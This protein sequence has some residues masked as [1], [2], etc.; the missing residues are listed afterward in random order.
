[1]VPERCH[2]NCAGRSG[3]HNKVPGSLFLWDHRYGIYGIPGYGMYV[4]L[5][6]S[7]GVRYAP[8]ASFHIELPL[9]CSVSLFSPV[10]VPGT[11]FHNNRPVHILPSYIPLIIQAAGRNPINKFPKI[12][13]GRFRPVFR[14]HMFSL[15]GW[16]PVPLHECTDYFPPEIISGNVVHTNPAGRRYYC[17]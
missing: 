12:Q 2:I 3:P 6:D 8:T 5:N 9:W 16:N 17:C 15:T 11:D 13:K 10:Y 1:M 4:L 14:Q 7:S